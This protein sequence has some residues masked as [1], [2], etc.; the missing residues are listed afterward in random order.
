MREC[1]PLIYGTTNDNRWRTKGILVLTILI[2]F[3]R[4]LIKASLIE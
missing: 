3:Q 4:G 1:E 2:N